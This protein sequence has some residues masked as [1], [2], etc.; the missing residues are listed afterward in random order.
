MKILL[1]IS[2]RRRFGH[3]ATCLHHSAAVLLLCGLSLPPP[4]GSLLPLPADFTSLVS[5]PEHTPYLVAVCLSFS[6]S[7]AFLSFPS[8]LAK[9]RLLW[10]HISSP[11]FDFYTLLGRTNFSGTPWFSEYSLWIFS[12]S[13]NFYLSNNFVFTFKSLLLP[14]TWIMM[15]C[16]WIEWF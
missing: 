3:S 16:Y 11:V 9:G 2:H 5:L 7:S 14:K 15:N 10:P 4:S 8:Y 6:P 1:V 13:F 12:S